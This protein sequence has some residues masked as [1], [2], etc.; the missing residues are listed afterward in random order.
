ERELAGGQTHTYQIKLT[1]G[2]F[3]RVVVEQKGIDV[4]VA[5]VA[6]DGKQ[7]IEANLSGTFGQEPLSHEA[8]VSG[9]YRIIVRAI[10]T[11]AAKG[12]YNALLEVK[13]APTAQDK[14]RITA[15]RLLAEAIKSNQQGAAAFETTV[16][17]AQQAL[18]LWR[19]LTDKY[20]EAS[21]LNL[22]GNAYNNRSKYD[23]AIE[24]YS[25][26]LT[27]RREVKDLAG[28]GNTLNNLALAHGSLNRHEKAIEY[29]EQA[30]AIR[31]ELKDSA[32]EAA[33]LN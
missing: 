27:I 23:Q 6:P 15:E 10:A 30:L 13:A 9:D 2:Q 8:A 16:E 14:Q 1:A 31:R 32:G 4:A 25:Q 12:V 11:T 26:A 18:S 20:W 3:L 24:Y 28:E 7:L 5:L 21:T 22:I 29:H 17:K 33:T 19:E